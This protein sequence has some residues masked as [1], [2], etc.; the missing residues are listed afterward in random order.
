[1]THTENRKAPAR[2]ARH[3]QRGQALVELAVFVPFLM[4]VVVG[5][6]DV[7][8]YTYYSIQVNNAARAGAQYGAQNT[9][10]ANSST[11]I[12]SA[13]VADVSTTPTPTVSASLFCVC[14][15]GTT[16]QSCSPTPT[17]TGSHSNT[18]IEVTTSETIPVLFKF[19]GIP[20]SLTIGGASVMR[21]N[22]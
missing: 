9:T 16:H 5:L 21:V 4:L 17:C 18:Y 13:A 11:G 1:M 7:G 6:I 14:A 22:N 12:T 2:A 19:P 15:N 10:S 8:R 20:N 3:A